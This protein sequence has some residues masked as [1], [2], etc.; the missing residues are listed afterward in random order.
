MA[1]RVILHVGTHKTGTTSLQQFLRDHNNDL[2]ARA[3]A[4][5][6]PGYL[7][8]SLHSDLPLL[9]IRADRMWPAR[10]RFPETARASWIGAAEAHVRAQTR[11]P[12]PDVLVYSHEDLSYLRFA[13]EFARLHELLA[14][15]TVTV[16]MVLREKTAFLQS[17]GEQLDAM[18]FHT[19]D[20]PASFAYVEPDSW[21][22]DY[23]ELVDGYRQSFGEDNVKVLD[24]DETVR[25]EGS[26]IPAVADLLQIPR[27]SLPPLE[28]YRLNR[29]GKQ[30]RPTDE[31]LAEIRERLAQHP[32]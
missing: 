3:D 14:P 5:F 28:S 19:S 6:P 15:R 25:D 8:P 30:W 18:G 7:I 10:I 4:F 1:G 31:Q 27:S 13:D 16:V 2:L 24:Y 20:D 26:V 29:A 22:V 21:L 11:A 9:S 17:Y 23:V 12:S 32:H